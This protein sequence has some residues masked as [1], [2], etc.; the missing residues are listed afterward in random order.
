MVAMQ[1]FKRW[2]LMD[3]RSHLAMSSILIKNLEQ[4]TDKKISRFFFKLGA[5]MPDVSPGLRF[6][7]HH[8]C[9]SQRYVKRYIE[10][11]KAEA[12]KN[13]KLSYLLGKTSHFMAD[14]F[15][16]AHNTNMG[17]NP[18]KH[19]VYEK[20]LATAMVNVKKGEYLNSLTQ[21]QAFT[22]AMQRCIISY[23]EEQSSQHNLF[24]D[25]TA[26][27]ENLLEDIVNAIIHSIHVLYAMIIGEEPNTAQLKDLLAL[28]VSA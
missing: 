6:T 12:L 25:G 21:N 14:T 22:Q 24:H 3:L 15:C 19:Y 27:L 8:I 10:R 7:E 16:A 18:A 23:I 11:S 20:K 28:G 17:K 2:S 5:V 1:F 26:K 4:T 13:F 9:V